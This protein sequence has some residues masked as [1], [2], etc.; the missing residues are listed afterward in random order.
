MNRR[1]AKEVEALQRGDLSGMGIYTLVDESCIRNLRALMI[2][3]EGTPYA[4]CPLLFTIRI[5]EDYPLSPP[6]VSIDTSDGVSRLHPN[7]YVGGKVCLSILGTYSGPKWTS[8]M[9]IETV[10]KSI[11]SLLNDNPIT[12][13]P[14]WER[15]TFA[16]APAKQYAEV[17]EFALVQHTLSQYGIFLAGEDAG[18]ETLWGPFREVIRGPWQKSFAE[19]TTMIEARALEGEKTYTSLPYGLGGTT[20]WRLAA[21]EARRLK[22]TG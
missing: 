17:V 12:N 8:T 5:P 7:L 15:Y 6:A 18:A 13:E 16:D 20:R 2:G 9:S 4:H 3:P 10:L 22:L 14:G 1:L 11:F 19:L 21:H